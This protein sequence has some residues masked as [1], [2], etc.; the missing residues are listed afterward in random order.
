MRRLES[1]EIKELASR[2]G[3]KKIAV[4]NFLISMIANPNRYCATQNAYHDQKLYGWNTATINAILDGID[5]S[6]DTEVR[7][8]Q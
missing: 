5:L 8:N 6:Y 1:D 3:V 2:R 7:D 4:E